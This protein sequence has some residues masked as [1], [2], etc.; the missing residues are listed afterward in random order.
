[1]HINEQKL[2][3]NKHRIV[4]CCELLDENGPQ[5]ACGPNLKC[6]YNFKRL[7]SNG[8]KVNVNILLFMNYTL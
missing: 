6:G 8:M 4:E 2:K 3:K 1:M 7:K 5:K